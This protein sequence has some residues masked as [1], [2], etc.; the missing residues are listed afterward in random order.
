[1]T[2]GTNLQQRQNLGRTRIWG[3]QTDAEY[4]LGSSWRFFGAYL[5]EQ[6]KVKENETNPALIGKFLAQVPKHRGTAQVSYENPRFANVTFEVQGVGTQFDDDLNTR[7]VPGI[8]DPGLPKYGIASLSV[9]RTLSHQVD[10]F[11]A[12]QNIF[13]Q[14]YFVGTLPT[15]IGPPRLVSVGLRLRLQGR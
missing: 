11:V 14:E 6:A 12:A 13:D 2:V 5:Y 15:L 8:V 10:A 1:V 4:R 7:A 3:L 9:S